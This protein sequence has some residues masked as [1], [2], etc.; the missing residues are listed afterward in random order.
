MFHVVQSMDNINHGQKANLATTPYKNI[1][2]IWPI[3][4][5]SRVF[6][7]HSR[8]QGSISRLSHTKDSKSGTR[9]QLAQHSIIKYRSRIKWNN[10]GK[11][12]APF[13]IPWSNR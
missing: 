10:L 9:G 8:A 7:Y 2:K 3:C 11:G 13:P 6:A 4:Q 12:V 1:H 5:A